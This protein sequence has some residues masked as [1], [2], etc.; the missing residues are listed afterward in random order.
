MLELHSGKDYDLGEIS[1]ILFNDSQ[2]K[3]I[4]FEYLEETNNMEIDLEGIREWNYCFN[5]FIDGEEYIKTSMKNRISN[6]LMK[7]G[8]G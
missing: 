3:D 4:I 5:R 1:E 6:M 7:I 8:I 2:V